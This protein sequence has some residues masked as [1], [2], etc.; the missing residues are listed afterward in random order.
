MAVDNLYATL[1]QYIQSNLL[2]ILI[3]IVSTILLFVIMPIIYKTI[4]R[5]FDSKWQFIYFIFTALAIYLTIKLVSALSFTVPTL[6]FYILMALMIRLLIGIFRYL[7]LGKI[8]L[9]IGIL[10]LFLVDLFV[11]FVINLIFS[12][13]G[14]TE[15]VLVI[16][17]T[18]IF[19]R[20]AEDFVDIEKIKERRRK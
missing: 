9:D 14:L 11:I 17:F 4:K 16:L 1:G 12:D 6:I 5:P 2:Y 7:S 3:F 13:I 8:S 19:I 18:A 15:N 10:I 20:L